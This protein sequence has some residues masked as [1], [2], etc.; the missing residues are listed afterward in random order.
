ML[1]YLQFPRIDNRIQR[2]EQQVKI[3]LFFSNSNKQCALG[4]D[5]EKPFRK[6]ILI[7]SFIK[8]SILSLHNLVVRLSV[9]VGS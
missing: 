2:S 6:G 3:K 9:V 4:R 1:G 7:L 8:R 5:S